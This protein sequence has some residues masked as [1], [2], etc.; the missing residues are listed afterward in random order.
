MPA[1]E[2][3]RYNM[4]RL[5]R[6]FAVCSVLLV[7]VT[8][9][10]LA[11]DH[12]RPW[13]AIQRRSDRIEL[14]LAQ[15]RYEQAMADEVAGEQE[16]L[17]LAL[18][19]TLS[20]S[21]SEN[22]IRV[23]CEAVRE[24]AARRQTSPPSFESL[25]RA[26]AALETA[27]AQA[28]ATHKA[29][30]AAVMQADKARLEAEDAWSRVRQEAG[31]E[32]ELLQQ[33]A[34]DRDADC[35]QARS[36][37]EAA[38]SAKRAAEAA[39]VPL[40][41]RVFAELDDLSSPAQFREDEILRQR[42][43]LLAA[44]DVAKARLGFAVRDGLPATEIKQLQDQIDALQQRITDLSREAEAAG[45]HGQELASIRGQLGQR[46]EILRQRIAQCRSEA[47]RFSR[48]VADKQSN[49]VD[50]W[51]VVPLPGKK[52]LELPFLD[53]F[54]SPRKIDNVWSAGLDRSS[55]SFGR[56]TR[57]DRCTT[58]HQ[59][60]Q[61]SHPDEP[62]TPAQ[63]APTMLEL[64]L[65]L[66]LERPADR[67]GDAGDD[68]PGLESQL[69]RYFGMQLADSGLLEPQDVT[70][71]TVDP[72]GPARHARRWDQVGR[73]ERGGDIRRQML[74][75]G[76]AASTGDDRV[77]TGLQGADVIVAVD[78]QNVPSDTSA[79]RWVIDR[80]LAAADARWRSAAD[81][82]QPSTPIRLLV[83]RGLP[84]PYAGHPRLDLFLGP[85]SPHPLNRFGC[86]VCHEGQGSA[87]EFA[88][89]S[90]TPNDL[91]T[92]ARWRSTLGWFDNRHWE[93]PMY[94]RRFVESSCL[95]C[96]H[97]VT[98]L[99]VSDRYDDP[100]A[101]Q[102]THG[103]RLI[104]TLGCFGCHEIA[105]VDG[106]GRRIG[107]DLRLEPNYSAA[108]LEF[109][110]AAGTGFD[111]L[112]DEEK[113]LVD[114]LVRHPEDDPTRLQVCELLRAD[115]RRAVPLTSDILLADANAGEDE[116][117]EMKPRF[118]D[119]VHQT[120]TP[121][122][123]TQAFPG[124]LRKVGPSLRFV[125]SKLDRAFLADWIT[126]PTH[127]RPGTRMP[128]SFGL[129][130]H[131]PAERLRARRQELLESLQE[132]SDPAPGTVSDRRQVEA[133][134]AAVDAELDRL[135]EVEKRFEP[136]AIDSMVQYLLD[137]SQPF[138]VI[139]P[140]AGVTPVLTEQDQQ[141]QLAR[142]KVA[143]EQHG[144]LACHEHADFPAM[145]D[146]READEIVKGPDLSDLAAKFAADRN[147]QGAAWLYS[148]ITDPA[149]Y[150][151]RTTM[152]SALLTPEPLRDEAGNV[153]GVVDPVA[154]LVAYLINSATPNWQP[155]EP[156]LER[157]DAEQQR[158]LDELAL[159]Y[160]QEKYSLADAQRIL[161]QGIPSSAQ[162]DWQGAE[163]ELFVSP[164]EQGQIAPE[165]MARKRLHYVAHKALTT[166]GCFACHDI[167]GMESAKPIG[168]GLNDWG[169]KSTSQLAFGHVAQYL[170]Q[171]QRETIDSSDRE[172]DA[173][174]VRSDA[175]EE[176]DRASSAAY[177]RQQL[178]RQTRSGFAFQ[179]L[180]EPRSFDFSEARN[181]KYTERLRM[182]QF[183]L[184]VD[185]R[186]AIITFLLGLVADPP[187]STYVYM[188]DATVKALL[189]GDEV[190]TRYNCR[191]CHLV[192]H[193]KW[194]LA[195][196][197]DDFGAQTSQTTFPFVPQSFD[198]RTLARSKAIDRQ[199]LRRAQIEGMP[200]IGQ[201]GL[202]V[203]LDDEEFP[204]EE[205]EDERFALD[206]LIYSFSLRKAAAV[207]GE[208]YQ[209]G[210]V[211]FDVPR[212]YLTRRQRARGG[213][214]AKYLLPR[215]VA[216]E[217]EVNPNAKG[218]EAWAWLP[219]TL[220]GEG[221]KTQ[222][223][224][225]Y[226]YLLEPH[227]IR[228]A[229]VMRMPRY[230]LSRA[231]AQQLVDYFAARDQVSHPYHFDPLRQP[232][233]LAQQDR[234]Y[235]ERLQKLADEG[236]VQLD[237]PF[238]NRHL[239]DAM[240]MVV[241][242]N[243]CVKCH[244]IG[245]FNPAGIERVKAPDLAQVYQR[246]RAPYVRTWLAKPTAIQPYTSMP[247]NIPYDPSAPL[248]G[249][250]VPQ[251][252]YHGTSIEQLDALVDLLM[253]YDRFSHG[254]APVTPLV[255]QNATS[256]EQGSGSAASE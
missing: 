249:T 77:A 52:W 189:Q 63:A 202:P 195:F 1:T 68:P 152:P 193:E 145:A 128:R 153:T 132:H 45:A 108:A 215:V 93:F 5:H 256:A 150:S 231:E 89:A 243:Y 254:R 234:Q 73:S 248:Q 127:F 197:P 140:P 240:R 119:Y 21:L 26:V 2:Q 214:L 218:S 41:S 88:W 131:L 251:E 27:A 187:S 233:Y 129:W 97:D 82:D 53:A 114:S 98:E 28:V 100:P 236:T 253:N 87:T 247:V 91:E 162:A 51:G 235:A 121:L 182:P 43:E 18:S 120:L 83:R 217:K 141:A 204:L 139:P 78:G 67:A 116:P 156:G 176:V 149:A 237:G 209:V 44:L 37:L 79:R 168:P 72:E 34:R 113:R 24:D 173:P 179:K 81:D 224:W 71:R 49:Y 86:S 228:P 239:A 123:Q 151:A 36:E 58:C 207:D 19:E 10:M 136:V 84:H 33:A 32:S 64:A 92:R 160:L 212:P 75:A 171:Q 46:E 137:R 61:S 40:R 142:G 14:R 241:S 133:D 146:F 31:S 188:P 238:S 175:S 124:T 135:D 252:L 110:G 174:S 115:A 226:T 201:D 221:E 203:I 69:R 126:Q 42:K 11:G 185:Q 165:Q 210:E 154:D 117:E 54:N 225:L 48:L 169:R 190:M 155:A 65:L 191:S 184:T 163:R 90:H 105:G 96:H 172:S 220:V 60:I 66:P 227:L 250:T 57:F 109:R 95:K 144:C 9:W 211:A 20:Q 183:S 99:D 194:D 35:R 230:N 106:A 102:V 158:A 186:E 192:Q 125:G 47:D 50:F 167:P 55:G 8:I 157:W 177:Y 3:T 16:R 213:T 244:L 111:Q 216:R 15:W 13:K 229:T 39:V 23:Y 7:A 246:L 103:H 29:W 161:E 74:H 245:D 122:L 147:P 138:D 222:P 196:P 56:V 118:S 205:E 159:V 80:L 242:G 178:D 70:V 200:V 25:E 180:T 199:G 181:K 219:P 170:S 198:H 130:N 107:P 206:R 6:I 94:P 134:L 59:M 62:G 101:P 148:W 143:F 208:P 30:Q 17:E 104:R 38:V 22:L 76:N 255:E 232:A 4:K 12:A 85:D 112:T 166:S 164:A 223:E